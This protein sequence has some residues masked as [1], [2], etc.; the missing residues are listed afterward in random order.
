M[1]IKKIDCLSPEITL[2]FQNFRSHKSIISGIL[3]LLHYLILLIICVYYSSVVF[4]RVKSTFFYVTKFIDDPGITSI[5]STNLF[6]YLTFRDNYKYDPKVL[7][8]IG[9]E[10]RPV[11]GLSLQ[12]ETKINHWIYK[13]CNFSE[14]LNDDLIKLIPSKNTALCINEFYNYTT[15]KKY[16]R[17]ESGFAY[18]AMKHGSA[19]DN[20]L[21]YGI[22]IRKCKDSKEEKCYDEAVIKNN[23]LSLYSVVVNTFAQK[24]D[25]QDYK[26]PFVKYVHTFEMG[27]MRTS[28][29]TSNSHFR[30]VIVKSNSGFLYDS[31]NYLEGYSFSQVLKGSYEKSNDE[32]IAM[33]FFW[34][35]NQIEYYE[36]SYLQLLDIL[37]TISGIFKLTSSTFFII[38]YIIN[39]YVIVHDFTSY[40]DRRYQK[41]EQNSLH[42]GRVKIQSSKLN[43]A[44]KNDNTI[45]SIICQKKPIYNKSKLGYFEIATYYFTLG[46]RSSYVR[47]IIYLRRKILSEERMIKLYLDVKQF[48]KILISKK[49]T[50]VLKRN[51][52]KTMMF[53]RGTNDNNNFKNSTMTG[54]LTSLN[55]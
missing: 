4:L 28:V 29:M 33:I 49:S 13:P 35:E 24:V 6:H 25:V 20:S 3:T 19:N 44:E 15:G 22:F 39:K 51:F 43:A 53:K 52:G 10:M 31:F 32:V 55:K 36:R 47:K 45:Q 23:L 17:N 18:P 48:N 41:R 38:N 7:N 54:I 16:K 37:G 40:L 50:K 5:N 11:T 21:P 30:K 2:Y 14:I 9:A 1:I 42:G 27:I 12:D 26:N 8:I 34:M 46:R